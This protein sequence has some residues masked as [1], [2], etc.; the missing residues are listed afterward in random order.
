[1]HIEKEDIQKLKNYIENIRK[2][3]KEKLEK[4]DKEI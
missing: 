4:K 3:H 1:M 2:K